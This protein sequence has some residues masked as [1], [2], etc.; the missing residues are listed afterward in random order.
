MSSSSACTGMASVDGVVGWG[1]AGGNDRP[2]HH[3][4][5]VL[6][7]CTGELVHGGFEQSARCTGKRYDG[8]MPTGKST[9]E[10]KMLQSIQYSLEMAL[11]TSLRVLELTIGISAIGTGG[12]VKKQTRTRDEMLTAHS[13]RAMG[14]SSNT[15]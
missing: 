8:V 10:T 13:R 7:D 4:R 1:G 12:L 2:T 11:P 5:R 14:E 15:S 3:A 9:A 6:T